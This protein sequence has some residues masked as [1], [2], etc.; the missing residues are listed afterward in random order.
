MSLPVMEVL[1]G[2]EKRRNHTVIEYFQGI[3]Q[4]RE[5]GCTTEL[6]TAE[7][8]ALKSHPEIVDLD[9]Q[10]AGS[11]DDTERAQI[12]KLRKGA[13]KALGGK[14]SKSIWKIRLKRGETRNF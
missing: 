7:R 10:L 4:F 12:R 8:M 5:R 6:P 13:M 14:P 3:G 2:L 1:P 11:A 9:R